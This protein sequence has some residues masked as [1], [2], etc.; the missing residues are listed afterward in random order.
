MTEHELRARVC[1]QADRW[2]GKKESDGSHREIIDVYNRTMPLPRGYKMT[3]SD[4]W[5]AAF[6]SAVGYA[7]GLSWWIFPECGCNPMI[8]RYRK[9]GRWM[10]DDAYVPQPGDVIF[11]DWED[12]GAGDDLG[13][14]DHVGIV[15]RV[16]DSV[17]N[18]I[19]GNCGHAVQYTARPVNG[20]CI[21][22]YG[23]PDYAAAAAELTA[24]ESAG[25]D[26]PDGPNPAVIEVLD[27]EPVSEPAAAGDSIPDGPFPA[28]LPEDRCQVSLPVLWA[29]NG[30]EAVRAAQLL[31]RGRG[32][33]LGRAGADGQ[34]GAKTEAAVRH[35]QKSRGIEADGIIGPITWAK[36]IKFT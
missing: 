32:F 24:D 11:Y 4:P 35:F 34:F 6:V 29:G 27:P 9:A 33:D 26:A 31:L 18:I 28:A 16:S 10:E 13:A 17:I 8:E 25:A 3:Y 2:V 22:G 15:I 14:S 7:C 30:S 21:R 36:L 20:R 5:C 19:E 23:L 12:S 1:A